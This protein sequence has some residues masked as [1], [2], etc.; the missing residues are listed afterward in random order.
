VVRTAGDPASLAGPI[1]EIVRRRDRNALVTE[2]VTMDAVVD[3]AFADFRR[4]VRYLGL[5]AGVALL[6]AAVGL[7]GALAYHVSQQEHEI[8]VRL[9]IGATRA[10]VLTMVARRGAWLVAA[11]LVLGVGA[12]YPSTRL[13][14]SLLFE[15]VPLDPLT[16]GSAVVLLGAVAATACLVPAVRAAR[17]DPAVVLRSE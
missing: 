9:A 5:F 17:V 2:V 16:Y 15:T 12:A 7:Y 6:L 1:R 14:R 10:S 3:E 13:V 8:G 11:G 4:V